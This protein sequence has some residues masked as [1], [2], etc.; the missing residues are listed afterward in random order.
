MEG[1]DEKDYFSKDYYSHGYRGNV[2]NHIG[3]WNMASNMGIN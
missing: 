1:G 2:C 3:R